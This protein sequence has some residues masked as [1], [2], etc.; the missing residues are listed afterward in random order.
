MSLG[1]PFMNFQWP[2]CCILY[3]TAMVPNLSSLWKNLSFCYFSLKLWSSWFFLNCSPSFKSCYYLSVFHPVL[4]ENAYLVTVSTFALD[5]TPPVLS[6][7]H[8]PLPAC[9]IKPQSSTATTRQAR[10]TRRVSLLPG[11]IFC[12]IPVYGWRHTI[13]SCFFRTPTFLCSL[14]L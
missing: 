8:R 13:H 14:L 3:Y 2:L 1:K 7:T 12:I 9:W 10:P 4:E 6:V 5:S 11:F